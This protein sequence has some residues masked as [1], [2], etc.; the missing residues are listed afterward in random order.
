MLEIMAEDHDIPA[1][2]LKTLIRDAKKNGVLIKNG[3][4]DLYYRHQV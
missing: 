3:V 2:E 4:D 1:I